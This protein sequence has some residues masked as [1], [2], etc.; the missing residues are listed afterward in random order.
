MDK[1]QILKNA[2]LE[3]FISDNPSKQQL[4]HSILD[5]EAKILFTIFMR[6]IIPKENSKELLSDKV[7][8][9]M[10]LVMHSFDIDLPAIVMEHMM[11]VASMNKKYALPYENLLS[12]FFKHFGIPLKKE[13]TVKEGLD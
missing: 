7:L 3:F 13:E 2:K 10:Y 11:Y 12:L 9:L 6:C 8:Y 5:A 1:K 4:T